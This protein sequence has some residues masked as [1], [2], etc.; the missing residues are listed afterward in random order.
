MG[1]SPFSYNAVFMVKSK[2]LNMAKQFIH[3]VTAWAKESLV[4]TINVLGP[5]RP[6]IER[7]KGFERFNL[8]I[9]ASSR[10]DLHT[11]LKPWISQ[12]R[13]HPLVNRVKWSVDVD[14]TDF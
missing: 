9:Q 11:M 2:N 7:L 14:P 1:L 4:S 10:K 5:S 8:Y 6:T 13:Q 3:D 12:I